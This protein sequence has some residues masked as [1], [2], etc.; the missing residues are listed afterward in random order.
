MRKDRAVYLT[1]VMSALLVVAVFAASCSPA[2]PTSIP[3]PTPQSIRPTQ[4]PEARVTPLATLQPTQAPRLTATLVQE[5]RVLEL[6]WPARLKLGDSDTVRLSL[7][8][9]VDG[10]TVSAEFPEHQVR[11]QAVQVQ[12]PEGYELLAAARLEG[13]NFE[14]SPSS[15]Q[16]GPLPPGEG[17]TW[18][19]TVAPRRPGQQRLAIRLALRWMQSGE[20]ARESQVYARAIDVRVLSILGL[21]TSQA[22][23][24]SLAGLIVGGGLTLAAFGRRPKRARLLDRR[25]DPGL[26]LEVAPSIQLPRETEEP[27]RAVFHSYKRVMVESEF[28]SGYSGA[29]T[30]LIHPVRADGRTDAHTIVKLGER[31]AILRE[32]EN[33]EQYVKDSLP[34]L[35]ARIQN[36]PVT[37]RGGRYAALRYTFIGQPGRPPVS[38][39]E[40]LLADPN[41]ALLQQ[42]FES[43]GPGW[44]LQRRPQPFR[45]AVEYDRVLPAHYFVEPIHPSNGAVL[46]GEASPD[47]VHLRIGEERILRGFSRFE[48]RADGQ[49]TSIH[50][51]AQAG[52]PVLRLRAGGLDWRNGSTGRVTGDRLSFLRGRVAGL[53]LLGL[54]DPL[55][56]LPGA[57]QEMVSGSRSIVH[58]D[59]NLENILVGPN[60]SIWLIDFAQ[61]REGHPLSDFAHL[62]AELIAHVIAA[63]VAQPRDFLDCLE[64]DGYPLLDAV[65][66]MARACLFNPG[67]EREYHLALFV[68]CLGALKYDALS[69]HSRHLL[70]L[71]AAFV[72][73]KIA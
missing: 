62:E 24:A 56:G 16:V 14:I 22:M 23:A 61:T 67:E 69:T 2:S 49:S 31:S 39:R 46:D 68:T 25:P 30:L 27:L 3:Q 26:S 7:L 73:K 36:E 32:Y 47:A 60:G 28:R 11:S 35:T 51:K 40:A 66:G 54:P 41:P 33:Y 65:H 18:H 13:V 21:T 72:S 63:Q 12:R 6:E 70:Y 9:S 29:R 64:R 59:L 38:L 1:L 58:G 17:L 8:P 37:T 10:Y 43:F 19:W 5:A 34:P 50:G 52:H 20:V 71:T 53:E 48:P 55:P 57:L 42:V 15:E 45:L 4:A 44:W